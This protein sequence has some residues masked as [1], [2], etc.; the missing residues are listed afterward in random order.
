LA[1]LKPN[2][3]NGGAD[4]RDAAARR[5]ER[6]AERKAK[7]GETEASI[8]AE[9]APVIGAERWSWF[10]NNFL[11]PELKEAALDAGKNWGFVLRP[12]L[13]KLPKPVNNDAQAETPGFSYE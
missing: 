10:W 1:A 11:S 7:R 6:E 5:W 13:K 4:P 3:L 9:L 8:V 12:L 2:T